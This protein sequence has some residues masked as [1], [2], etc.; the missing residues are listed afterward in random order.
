[1]RVKLKSGYRVNF[2]IEV[3]AKRPSSTF[4]VPDSLQS[5]YPSNKFN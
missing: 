1:M 3:Y 5:S 2:L 4:A